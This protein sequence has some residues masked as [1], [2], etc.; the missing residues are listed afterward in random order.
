MLEHGGVRV[1]IT[2]SQAKKRLDE[3]RK[4][5]DAVAFSDFARH[6]STAQRNEL[7]GLSNKLLIIIKK[8][9]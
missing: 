9:Q 5:I 7:Y 3:A 1:K 8:M 2:R 4:K 6:L